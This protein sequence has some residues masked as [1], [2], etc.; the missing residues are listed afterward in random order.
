MVRFADVVYELNVLTA[1]ADS[2]RWADIQPARICWTG[3]QSSG[4]KLASR[5]FEMVL[6]GVVGDK[7]LRCKVGGGGN[8]GRALHAISAPLAIGPF[9][10]SVIFF[11]VHPMTL[12]MAHVRQRFAAHISD[13]VAEPLGARRAAVAVILREGDRDL[14]ILLVKRADRSGDPWSGHMALPGGHIAPED[15]SARHA[16]ERETHEEIGLDLREHGRIV[17]ML[18]AERPMVHVPGRAVEIVPFVYELVSS[19][20][21]FDLNCEIAELHWAAMGPMLRHE[22]LSR[23]EWTVGDVIRTM[24]AFDVN[25]RM[26]WGVTYRILSRLL[27]ILDPGFQAIDERGPSQGRHS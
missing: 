19:P 21:R 26:V 25:G 14:E 22:C 23:L 24:P 20:P 15:E 11:D 2:T 27:R 7:P 10:K 5:T 6:E 1:S 9:Q 3:Q 17:G 12:S 13:D 4:Y 18:A 8:P 16:A